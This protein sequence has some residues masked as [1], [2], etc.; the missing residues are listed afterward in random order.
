MLTA[1]LSEDFD[2]SISKEAQGM[3]VSLLPNARAPGNL[4]GPQGWFFEPGRS[5][6]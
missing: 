5:W 1:H 4:Q 6:G 2:D 3:A